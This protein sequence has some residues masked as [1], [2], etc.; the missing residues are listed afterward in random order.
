MAKRVIWSPLASQRRKE[1]LQFWIEHNQSNSY[2]IKLN[3]LFKEAEELISR[4][5]HIGKMTNDKKVRFKII[6][7]YSMFYE[8]I[9]DTIF[10]LTIW[11]NKQD[12]DK[13]TFR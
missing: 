7:D 5:P 4:Y 8:Q 12:P 11:S 6:R 13:F 3:E 1:I 9:E 10:I 2:S